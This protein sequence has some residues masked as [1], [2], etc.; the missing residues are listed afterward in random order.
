MIEYQI[1]HA[2]GKT[3]DGFDSYKSAAARVA[4]VYGGDV[5]IGHDGDISDGGK[6]TMCW[7]DAESSLDDDGS[8]ACC[9]IRRM[10]W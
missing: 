8:R 6:R 9:S 3:E 5:V 4:E 7:P 1:T 2:H 10:V